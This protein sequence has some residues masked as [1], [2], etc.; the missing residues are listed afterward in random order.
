[1][2][3]AAIGALPYGVPLAFMLPG[4]SLPIGGGIEGPGSDGIE[5]GAGP[6]NLSAEH[7][8]SPGS[9][10]HPPSVGLSASPCGLP[11]HRSKWGNTLQM[12]SSGDGS[13]I[14]GAVVPTA[15]APMSA[16]S[17]GALVT[18]CRTVEAM[19]KL[20]LFPLHR[21]TPSGSA[22]VCRNRANFHMMAYLYSV[23]AAES[24]RDAV[25]GGVVTQRLRTVKA[26][27]EARFGP[28]AAWAT[29][30][31]FVAARNGRESAAARPTTSNR[32][33]TRTCSSTVPPGQ[34]K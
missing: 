22:D 10:A 4:R 25:A 18:T 8:A 5:P 15:A 31:T 28:D 23:R 34:E 9:K 27:G 26:I 32:L 12:G 13:A 6:N 14:A 3:G 2:E 33:R 7:D 19:V 17:T 16:T 20:N 11:L 30:R 24:R 21:W 1:M 29:V